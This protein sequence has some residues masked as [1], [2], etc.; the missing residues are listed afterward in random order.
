M[1]LKPP[2]IGL[3]FSASVLFLTTQQLISQTV[4]SPPN[5]AIL[6]GSTTAAVGY[7]DGSSLSMRSSK[8]RFPVIAANA[9]QNVSIQ[10]RFAPNPANTGLI[11]APLDGGA[12]QP[13]Q[14]KASIAIDGTASIQFQPGT[15]PGLYRVLL[16]QAG[17]ISILHF[18]V[19][20][21]QR[22]NSGPPALTPSTGN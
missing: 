6:N 15:Q 4:G 12:V 3:A 17:A 5:D 18:W 14:G 2:L 19:A 21:P 10:L 9:G 8:G 11:A 1:K 7:P 20:D 22:P 16:N 13:S